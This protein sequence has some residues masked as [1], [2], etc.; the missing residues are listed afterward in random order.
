MKHWLMV[1]STLPAPVSVAVSLPERMGPDDLLL[2]A[3]N[4]YGSD[5][6]VT[7]LEL[8]TPIKGAWLCLPRKER[9]VMA[10]PE[11]TQPAVELARFERLIEI[12]KEFGT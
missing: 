11:T 4:A 9:M 3:R 6:S 1:I 2:W 5:V 8:D 10:I 12:S 7:L